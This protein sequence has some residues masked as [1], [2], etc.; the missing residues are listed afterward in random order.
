M[1][2][3]AVLDAN[4]LYPF[5][6]RDTLLRLAELELYTPLWSDRILDEMTRN[7][8]E[9]RLT[10]AQAAS[11]NQAMRFAFEEAEVDA[12]EIER[13]EPAMTNEAKDRHVLAAAVAADSELVVTL[14][15]DDFPPEACEPVGVEAVHPDDF[16]LD[17]HDLAPEAVR[18]ALEQQAGDLHPPWPLEQLLEALATAGVPR[19]VATVRSQ[20]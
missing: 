14:N 11:I 10:D 18:A 1:P 3:S 17:L 6:L 2:F 16:L 4:V 15:L 13:L 7:L 5:S 9:H 12:G 19:F 20:T 8:V